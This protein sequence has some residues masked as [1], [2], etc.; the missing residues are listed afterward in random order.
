MMYR[1]KQIWCAW[2]G[3]PYPA[4]AIPIVGPRPTDGETNVDFCEG[5]GR[6]L[7]GEKS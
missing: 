5:C 7:T 4:I 1:L 3:H 6:A 2:R